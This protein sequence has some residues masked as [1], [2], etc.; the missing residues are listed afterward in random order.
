M[1]KAVPPNQVVLAAFVELKRLLTTCSAPSPYSSARSCMFD[2]PHM[3]NLAERR[4]ALDRV[5]SSRL[6]YMPIHPCMFRQMA[7]P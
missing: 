3:Q 4:S 2:L 5:T 6:D 7:A 1:A